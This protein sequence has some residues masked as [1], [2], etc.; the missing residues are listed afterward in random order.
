MGGLP[1]VSFV[2]LSD[3][4]V[5][6]RLIEAGNYIYQM[7]PHTVY[8]VENPSPNGPFFKERSDVDNICYAIPVSHLEQYPFSSIR[9]QECNIA[10]YHYK[11]KDDAI[12]DAVSRLIKIGHHH[13]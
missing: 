3:A 8:V 12:A 4:E 1:V 7:N 6:A 5:T 11:Y 13:S 10:F 2:E 9:L